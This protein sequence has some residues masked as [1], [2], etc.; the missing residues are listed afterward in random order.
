MANDMVTA[1]QIASAVQSLRFDKSIQGFEFKPSLGIVAKN[2]DKF[3]MDIR[4]FREPLKRSVQQVMIPSFKQNFTVGGRPERWQGLSKSTITRRGSTGPIL[5]R[6]GKLRRGV[7]TLNIWS[8]TPSAATIRDLPSRIW[9]GKVHQAG[10]GG[11]EGNH[12]GSG[13][14]FAKYE[15]AAR[16][17][18]G[19]YASEGEVTRLGFQMF[20]SRT[21]KHGAAPHSGEMSSIPARPFAVFQEEDMDK[22]QE[23]FAEW[24]IER[25]R[26]AGVFSE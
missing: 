26:K 4:S 13:N 19:P 16:K 3:A 11:R 21:L 6:S 2:I 25:A 12:F 9:Y 8:I 5:V 18:L 20:D 22:I 14:W 15:R 10:F 23:V 17:S 1:S 7:T 24:L